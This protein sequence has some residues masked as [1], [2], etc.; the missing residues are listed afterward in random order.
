MRNELEYLA[1][2]ESYVLGN[3]RDKASFEQKMASSTQLQQDVMMLKGLIQGIKVQALRSEVQSVQQSYF[4]TKTVSWIGV[5][6]VATAI[7]L[8]LIYQMVNKSDADPNAS[9]KPTEN[10]IHQSATSPQ[11]SVAM[12]DT[13][14]VLST[15]KSQVDKQPVRKQVPIAPEKEIDKPTTAIDVPEEL[16]QPKY[17]IADSALPYQYYQLAGNKNEVIETPSGIIFSI[18]RNSFMDAAGNK[19]DDAYQLQIKEAIQFSDIMKAGLS[20]W[21]A[22]ELLETSGMFFFNAIKDGKDLRISPDANI[23]V[24]IPKLQ[25]ANDM[26]LFD[27]VRKTNGE[28]DWVNPQPQIQYLQTVSMNQLDFYPPAFEKILNEFSGI[29]TPDIRMDRQIRDSVIAQDK[30][31]KAYADSVYLSFAEDIGKEKK[32]LQE[33]NNVTGAKNKNTWRRGGVRRDY[34]GFFIH[35]FARRPKVDKYQR[36]V[37]PITVLS[38]WRT[39]F[40]GTILATRAFEERMKNIHYTCNEDV[41]RCYTDNMDKTIQYCDSLAASKLTGVSKENFLRFYEQKLTLRPIDST[42]TTP[43]LMAL[44]AQKQQELNE[45]FKRTSLA[46]L[47]KIEQENQEANRRTAEHNSQESQRLRYNNSLVGL[48]RL[49][50]FPWPVLP[51][52]PVATRNYNTFRVSSPGW[53]NADAIR[54]EQM[55]QAR[56]FKVRVD[57]ASKFDILEAYLIPDGQLSFIRMTRNGNEFTYIANNPA[58]YKL[59]VVG[60]QQEMPFTYS[61][62]NA[63]SGNNIKASLSPSSEQEIKDFVSAGASQKLS[64]DILAELDFLSFKANDAKKATVRKGIENLRM[65]LLPYVFPCSQQAKLPPEKRKEQEKRIVSSAA[66]R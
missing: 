53:K 4:I 43:E 26:Q 14:V 10:T 2:I 17:P 30:V 28:I 29:P 45:L 61:Q 52:S 65:I 34:L 56:T 21:S 12:I 9:N 55:M 44:F 5:A 64:D 23:T 47:E 24:S 59:A 11:K 19:I 58:D 66:V 36:G 31:S 49:P 1:E 40:N 32:K 16:Y 8:G 38:F 60:Y 39:E 3:M 50:A 57:S 25:A 15:K 13:S 6:V 54:L 51:V 27:G 48:S 62:S 46:T 7:V 18:P 37:N 42:S 35:L 41:L 63:S 20:T 22:N 33:T